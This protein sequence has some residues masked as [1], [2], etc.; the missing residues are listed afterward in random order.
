MNL[1]YFIWQLCIHKQK[2]SKL[3]EEDEWHFCKYTALTDLI[4]FLLKKNKKRLK[5][6]NASNQFKSLMIIKITAWIAADIRVFQAI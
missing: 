3:S 4:S 1:E 6:S 2:L 5:L